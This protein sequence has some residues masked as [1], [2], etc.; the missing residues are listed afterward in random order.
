[1]FVWVPKFIYVFKRFYL[2]GKFRI[3][4]WY[5]AVYHIKFFFVFIGTQFLKRWSNQWRDS[6]SQ[7]LS[8]KTNTQPFSHT[9]QIIELCCEYLSVLCFWLHVIIMSR[10]SF[11]MNLR[12]MVCMNIKETLARSRRYIC[13]LSDS[14]G[15]R[16]HNHLLGKRTLDHLVKL[17][18]CLNCVVSNY[19]Y[20]AFDC[21]LL[22]YH[23]PK[24]QIWRLLRVRSSLTFR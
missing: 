23:V 24:L 12:S 20:S 7:P 19:L 22:L 13:R 1:M 18:K 16:I 3:L 8:S 10:T 4:F 5:F 2:I 15:I 9:S 6:N 11:R 17:A 14:N 21:I